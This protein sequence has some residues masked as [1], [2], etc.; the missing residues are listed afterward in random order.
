[1]RHLG[2]A[3]AIAVA[4][5]GLWLLASSRTLS[6]ALCA[7][8]ALSI[9][10]ALWMQQRRSRWALAL[11]ATLALLAAARTPS[12]RSADGRTR[13]IFDDG[14]TIRRFAP[15]Q[16]VPEQDQLAMATHAVALVDPIMTRAS[17]ARLRE[18]IRRVYARE[19]ADSAS[20]GS[21]MADALLDQDAQ[22]MFV[23]EPERRGDERLPALIFLHGSAGSWRGYFSLFRSHAARAR[24]IVVQPS[25][26]FGNWSAEG[27]LDA[28]DRARR[29]AIDVLHADPS[30]I[31]LAG[32]SNGGL[33]IERA[34][35]DGAP[36]Y[37]GIV[38]ISSVLTV[39]RLRC[40][41]AE[42]GWRGRPALLVHGGRDDRIS[43]THFQENADQ[44]RS[45][46]F[47]VSAFVVEHEDH[48]LIFTAPDAVFARLTPWL[49]AVFT[50]RA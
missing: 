33:G 15:T 5:L 43:R 37:A 3:V 41:P 47:D 36:R 14:A 23:Y 9:A 22:R 16:L 25:F 45:I 38:A 4:A 19:D 12:G 10:A 13:V 1:M 26:G 49:A 17:A 48:Y 11:A 6:G 18:A 32:L 21:A 29:Y 30:R 31:V 42:L 35:C 24:Y 8:C 20:V 46:G 40:Q 7:S 50:P 44:M 28:I 34:L 27:G 2:R 39:D